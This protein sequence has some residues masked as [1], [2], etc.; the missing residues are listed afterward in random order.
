MSVQAITWALGVRVKSATHKAVLLV[1]ANYADEDGRC[2]PSHAT[3]AKQS[4]CSVSTVQR[5]LRD[6]EKAGLL[7]RDE[8]RRRD[9]TFTSDILQLLAAQPSVKLT[10]GHPDQRATTPSPAV[11]LTEPT[12]FEPTR[13][14]PSGRIVCAPVGKEAIE[15]LIVRAGDGCDQ[16]AP[17]L[18]HGA[19]LNRLLRGGCD[20]TEDI[21]PAVDQLAQSFRRRRQ[22]FN[23]W[24]LVEEHAIRNRDARLAGVPPPQPPS[25][26]PRR[27]GARP[28]MASVI[29]RMVTEGKLT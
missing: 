7:R 19:V 14:E 21:L 23:T 8:R 1:V 16:T 20:W 18:H 15:A 10:D 27:N 2:W 17:N 4:E 11:N 3:I 29:D 13:I 5:A 25:E 22:R 26:A 12:T 6:L 9:G 28:S 24:A